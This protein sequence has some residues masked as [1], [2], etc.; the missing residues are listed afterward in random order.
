MIGCDCAVCTSEDARNKRSRS[1]VVV[2]AGE[3][4]LLV[5]SGPDLRM[6]ALREGLR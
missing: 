2:R 6:Q 5:D 3:R 4:T 1:S